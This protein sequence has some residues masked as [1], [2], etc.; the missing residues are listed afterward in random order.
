MVLVI[1]KILLNRINCNKITWFIKALRYSKC[2]FAST[3]DFAGNSNST[4]VAAQ[5]FLPTIQLV[6][7]SNG[8][9]TGYVTTHTPTMMGSAPISF[10]DGTHQVKRVS[11]IKT[12]NY[13]QATYKFSLSAN[14]V[15]API[16]Q[17]FMYFTTIE[18]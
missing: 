17:R 16:K 11:N 1:D 3:N 13:Y 6:K 2:N 4:S 12:G 7:N 14:E 15:E 18:L 5:Y 9:Y 10:M 8:S